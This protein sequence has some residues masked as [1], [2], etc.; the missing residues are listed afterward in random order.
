[1]NENISFD[2]YIYT[3]KLIFA[4]RNIFY[5]VDLLYICFIYCFCRCVVVVVI[6][7][8]FSIIKIIIII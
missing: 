8:F 3:Y 7:S 1:M 6:I 4:I 5:K 2:M